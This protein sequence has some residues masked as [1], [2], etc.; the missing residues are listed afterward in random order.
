[1]RL[2]RVL[3]TA[4]TQTR[5][6]RDGGSAQSDDGRLRVQL[7]DPGTAGAGT[8]P[9]Q[10]FAVGWSACFLSAIR[11]LAG[12]QKITLPNEVSVD[13]EVDLGRTGNGHGLAARLNVTLAGIDQATA[14]QLVNGASKICPYSLAVQ[15]NIDV[16][17]TASTT[18]A[19]A[20]A[21]QAQFA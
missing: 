8:N 4:K 10:L 12:K 16:T 7:S 6:G 5:G 17:Y 1:M 14:E 21:A 2:D 15:G 13:T 18:A 9:E 19:A 11:I 20:P 3:Y